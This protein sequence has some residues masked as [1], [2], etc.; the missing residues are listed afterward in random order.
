MQGSGWNCMDTPRQPLRTDTPEVASGSC[1]PR[2]Q[3]DWVTEA[4]T[5]FQDYVSGMGM[6]D[7][8]A[9]TH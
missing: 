1:K 3:E 9:S 2:A 6:G 4:E 5:R 8:G 7:D